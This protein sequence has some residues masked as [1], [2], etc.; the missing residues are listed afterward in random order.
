MTTYMRIM[1]DSVLESCD[2]LLEIVPERNMD[3]SYPFIAAFIYGY[4]GVEQAVD[5]LACTAYGR[6]DRNTY[7]LAER[8]VV[9][10]DSRTAHLVVHVQCDYH[11]LVHIYQ[12]GGKIEI[13]LE[14]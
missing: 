4:D 14:I 12:L 13:A 6:H 3:M 2:S 10:P 11:W 5:S 9:E 7:H 1:L 8:L